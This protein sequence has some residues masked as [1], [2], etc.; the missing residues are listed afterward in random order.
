M[1]KTPRPKAL[2]DVF[3]IKIHGNMGS[4][5]RRELDLP[6]R[7]FNPELKARLATETLV[8]M[9]ARKEADWPIMIPEGHDVF[10]L[11]HFKGVPNV[12]LR[13]LLSEL[14]ALGYFLISADF[15][16]DERGRDLARFVLSKKPEDEHLKKDGLDRICAFMEE[17]VWQYVH[18]HDRRRMH[19]DG[20]QLGNNIIDAVGDLQSPDRCGTFKMLHLHTRAEIKDGLYSYDFV[21]HGNVKR[22]APQRKLPVSLLDELPALNRKPLTYTPFTELRW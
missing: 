14:I 4:T 16:L 17:L 8:E 10:Q 15:D 19:P 9:E 13:D 3:H 2:P 12:C 22:E 7:P 18:I 1:I 6:P 20:R 11:H 5:A 21:R